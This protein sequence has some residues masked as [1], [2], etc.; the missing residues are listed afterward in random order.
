M[1]LASICSCLLEPLAKWSS[2]MSISGRTHKCLSWDTNQS[3][4]PPVDLCLSEAD[5]SIQPVLSLHSSAESW[6]AFSV[7]L[8][9]PCDAQLRTTGPLPMTGFSEMGHQIFTRL[10]LISLYMRCQWAESVSVQ[11]SAAILS[12]ESACYNLPCDQ[13]HHTLFLG[14]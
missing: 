8:S 12:L 7:A 5:L 13:H 1:G 14:T 11:M 4:S 2:H 3:R 6:Q 10:C 9:S